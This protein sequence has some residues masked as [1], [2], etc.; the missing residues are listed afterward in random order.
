MTWPG[1][2]V[3][4]TVDVDG[5]HGLPAGG[6]GTEHRLSLRSE[7]EYGVAR[8][9]PRIAAVLARA[10]AAATFYVPGAVAA[11]HDEAIAAL[12]EAGHEIG[13]HGHL[14]LRPDELDTGAQ[15]EELASGAAALSM[16]SPR[17][18]TGYRAPGWEL[19]AVTLGALP[20]HGITHDSSLMGDDRPY[21]L[22]AAEVW[23][24]PV[25]WSLDDAPHF[26]TGG[27]PEALLEVWLAELREAHA[28]GRHVTFTMHPEIIGRPHRLVVLERLIEAAL[29]RG[30][31]IAPHSAVVEQLRGAAA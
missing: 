25:H 10:G 27:G 15:L 6:V 11:A 24:L 14:H 4:L 30:A 26:A 21:L 28:E 22:R 29:S 2:A 7:R 5:V 17:P 3:S 20:P 1:F 13:H 19:T 12:G 9:L 23:E 16:V 31:W 18:V 8:G